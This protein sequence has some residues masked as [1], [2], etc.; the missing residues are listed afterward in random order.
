MSDK[1]NYQ[2]QGGQLLLG[3]IAAYVVI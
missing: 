3:D 2:A 1:S